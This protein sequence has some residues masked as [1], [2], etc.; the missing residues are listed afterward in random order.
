[1]GIFLEFVKPKPVQ[2]PRSRLAKETGRDGLSAAAWLVCAWDRRTAFGQFSHAWTR[3]ARKRYPPPGEYSNSQRR[4]ANRSRTRALFDARIG[5]WAALVFVTLPG[6]S[7]ASLLITTDAPLIF[8]W[9]VMLFFWVMLVKR[10]N[11][12][13]ASLL[14][15][16]IGIGLLAKQAM[17]YALVCI[18]C[19]AAMSR[20][21]PTR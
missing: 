13:F 18:A 16:A 21:A 4:A 17:I 12:R 8:L 9:T 1:M 2:T 11:M 20:E 19:H 14:G 7:Y 15:V 10:Q 5:F 6:V 3:G